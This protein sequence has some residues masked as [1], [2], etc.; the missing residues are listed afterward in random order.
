VWGRRRNSKAQNARLFQARGETL[1]SFV[2][3]DATP[4]DIP[5]LARLHVTAWNAAYAVTSGPTVALRE[6]QWRETFAKPSGNW[7]VLLVVDTKGDLVGFTRTPAGAGGATI[8]AA[9]TTRG[10]SGTTSS[11][12]RHAVRSSDGRHL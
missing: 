5:A 12:S 3:R 11:R 1:A 4:A 10:T 6:R 9:S 2:I 8:G 7:F